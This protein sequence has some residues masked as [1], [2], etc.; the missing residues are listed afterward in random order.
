MAFE[1]GFDHAAEAVIA[2]L[3]FAVLI[4][5]VHIHR[6]DAIANSAQSILDDATDPIRQCL[7]TFDVVVSSDLNLHSALLV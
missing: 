6:C 2:S 1:A 3:L 5:Q 7:M 4:A